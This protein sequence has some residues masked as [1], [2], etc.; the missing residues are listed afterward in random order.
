MESVG[1]LAETQYTVYI[2]AYPAPKVSWMKDDQALSENYYIS[3]KT[4]HMEGNR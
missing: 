4:S 2:N 1:I 3:S